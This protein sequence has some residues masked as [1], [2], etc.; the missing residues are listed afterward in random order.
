MPLQQHAAC[1]ALH[2]DVA[3]RPQESHPDDL[4]GIGQRE[5]LRQRLEIGTTDKGT[6]Q[7]ISRSLRPREYALKLSKRGGTERGE[8]DRGR[9]VLTVIC[10][11]CGR[12]FASASS[13]ILR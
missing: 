3:D 12:S 11:G 10:A 6:R 5:Q 7:R 9:R 4:V 13:W 8:A 2:V 1:V